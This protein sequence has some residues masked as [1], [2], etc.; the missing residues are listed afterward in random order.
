MVVR[1]QIGVE[2]TIIILTSKP[3]ILRFGGLDILKIQKVLKKKIL[4]NTN[5]KNK[6]APGQFPFIIHQVF[7]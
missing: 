1:C 6:I 2:S 7:H 5:S 3:T 4:I